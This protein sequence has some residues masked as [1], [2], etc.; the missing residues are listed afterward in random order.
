M[1]GTGQSGAGTPIPRTDDT[2][3]FWFFAPAN[4]E[5][6][7]QDP[8]GRGVNGHFW[9]FYASL[10]DVEFDLTVTDTLTGE[11]RTYHNPAGTM[12]S[13]ADTLAF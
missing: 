4:Y 5:T 12:A 13:R 7:R 3:A 11:Q 8:R 9:V 2:G 1:A 6:R 10:T